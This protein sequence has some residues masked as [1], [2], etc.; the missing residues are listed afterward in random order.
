MLSKLPRD[1]S[2]QEPPREVN[3]IKS[4]A[5]PCNCISCIVKDPLLELMNLAL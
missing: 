4:L 2:V 3:I 1:P 5:L